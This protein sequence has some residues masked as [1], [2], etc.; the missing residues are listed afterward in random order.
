M[1]NLNIEQ[2]EKKVETQ[3]LKYYKVLGVMFEV[4]K[5]RYYFE[6]TD[7]TEYKK[8]DKVIV[9]TVRGKELGSVYGEAR[10]LPET[11]LVL[12][13]KPVIKKADEE[14][15]AKYTQLKEEAAKAFEICKDRIA[16]HK[17]PMKL[18]ETEYTFDKTKLI[19][20]F[21]AEG[22]IDF[23]EL[24]KDLAN[25]FRLRIELRQI[26]VRD[27][28]RILGTIGICGKELCCRT[29]INKFDSVSIKMAR[30]QGLVINPTKISGVC[31]RLLCCIN[32]EYSQYEEVLRK[33]PA[34]NQ[35]V[36]TAKGEGKVISISPLS[37]YMF[38][39]IEDKGIMKFEL[40]EV[41]FN[42]REA[43]KLKN[44]KTAEE[45]EH[46]ELEKE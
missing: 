3:E 15:L 16:Q 45:I 37:G 6:V 5:K 14:E 27:E 31:G 24:V 43:N 4:T 10:M 18:V 33:Y 2:E 17:L 9:D 38:V 1:E 42:R 41:K 39:D 12:P 46:S 11:E 25:I 22:R 26:G 29:F 32:Y 8:G 36:R 21:T 40:H 19:F 7:D 34:V 28:A 44:V 13:L 20:Y 35:S 30:D 23:R